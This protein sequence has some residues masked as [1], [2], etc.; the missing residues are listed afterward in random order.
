MSAA[1]WAGLMLA[2]GIWLHANIRL[3]QTCFRYVPLL[4]GSATKAFT[5]S[6]RKGRRK[7]I[8][9]T[10]KNTIACAY[11]KNVLQIT[12]KIATVVCIYVCMY[13]WYVSN[14]RQ[15]KATTVVVVYEINNRRAT[16]REGSACCGRKNTRAFNAWTYA[17]K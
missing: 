1:R 11:S 17:I 6:G 15:I 3:G 14:K 9:T 2:K 8:V 10:V 5:G 7:N 13:V 12:I 16:V 4:N